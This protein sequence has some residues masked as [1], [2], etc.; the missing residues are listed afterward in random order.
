VEVA[1][2][3][4]GV[5]AEIAEACKST[6]YVELDGRFIFQPTA[7]ESLGQVNNSAKTFLGVLGR[8]INAE[9]SGDFLFQ[10][11]SVL[12]QRYDDS[13]VDEEEAGTGIPA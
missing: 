8:R 9:I 4:A 2:R 12:I 7:V 13:F 1:A 6:E 10:W 5:V 11:L 3:D